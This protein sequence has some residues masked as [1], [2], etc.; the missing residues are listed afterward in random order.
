MDLMHAGAGPEPGS[1]AKPFIYFSTRSRHQWNVAEYG[2]SS[3][4]SLLFRWSGT[5]ST[6]VGIKN[7]NFSR[8]F[9]FL[10]LINTT[11]PPSQPEHQQAMDVAK[12]KAA[13]ASS[14]VVRSVKGLAQKVL[15]VKTSSAGGA[16][17]PNPNSQSNHPLAASANDTASPFTTHDQAV[18]AG[19]MF[20]PTHAEFTLGKGKGKEDNVER[21]VMGGGQALTRD[22]QRARA[23]EHVRLS[24]DTYQ[25]L[26]AKA[27]KDNLHSKPSTSSL[28]SLAGSGVR[29]LMDQFAGPEF[30][31][32]QN[33]LKTV[34]NHVAAL[35]TGQSAQIDYL[36]RAN[37]D[38]H[39]DIQTLQHQVNVLKE[40]NN[41][42]ERQ[43]LDLSAALSDSSANS[44][45]FFTAARENSKLT[46]E[47]VL[48]DIK[49]KSAIDLLKKSGEDSEIVKAALAILGEVV[50]VPAPVG[51]QNP[52]VEDA[53]DSDDH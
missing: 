1:T 15:G 47:K 51:H 34:A 14:T 28:R 36:E 48:R 52:T 9:F 4:S 6:C 46:V 26:N 24:M 21:L 13:S 16:I 27:E 10:P 50:G 23:R 19:T 5:S 35:E 22:E 44:A 17:L 25:P 20:S 11:T 37:F 39:Y 43:I 38:L 40:S 2:R 45:A 30:Q 53:P 3:E 41:K 42:A 29:H 7:S 8:K 33:D 12:I 32:L 49:I 31:P 18:T